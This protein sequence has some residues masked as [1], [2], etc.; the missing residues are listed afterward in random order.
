MHASRKQWNA[1]IAPAD[2]SR[3]DAL[4]RL[5][6][7]LWPE[8]DKKAMREEFRELL[9]SD[10]D[11]VFVADLDGQTVGFVH[12]SLRTDYVEGAASSPVGF[13]EG[14]YVDET[15]RRGGI[16]RALITACEKWAKSR[17]CRELGSDTGLDDVPGQ[18]FHLKAGFREARRLVAYIKTIE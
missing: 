16:A 11:A 5:G 1:A 18:L 6:C 7:K 17:G 15:F 10:R 12:V 13:V 9:A 4:A 2:E 14:L 8:N 3:L